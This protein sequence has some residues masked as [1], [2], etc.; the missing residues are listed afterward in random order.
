MVKL[1][2]RKTLGLSTETS[3]KKVVICYNRLR[4]YKL[5]DL[6]VQGGTTHVE[7]YPSTTSCMHG[8][9]KGIDVVYQLMRV[10]EVHCTV[11]SF[12]QV[13]SYEVIGIDRVECNG[14]Y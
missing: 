8:Y 14:Y 12:K 13:S 4:K 5:D 1:Y 11:C 2:H 6:E 3:T 10:N 7:S 9:P